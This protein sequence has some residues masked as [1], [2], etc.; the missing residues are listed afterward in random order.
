MHASCKVSPRYFDFKSGPI[1]YIITSLGHEIGLKTEYPRSFL[2][3]YEIKLHK[4]K[5]KV[6]KSKSPGR[7]VSQVS[8][9]MAAVTQDASDVA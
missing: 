8:A 3:K 5:N 9:L 6:M 1:D 2:K 4:N 7:C